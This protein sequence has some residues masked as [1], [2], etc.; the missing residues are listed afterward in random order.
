MRGLGTDHVISGPITGLKKNLHLIAQT[1]R[2]TDRQCNSM[3]DSAQLGQF[4]EKLPAQAPSPRSSSDSSV[5]AESVD[6]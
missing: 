6:S 3:T 5:S 2:Q 4:S 1:D